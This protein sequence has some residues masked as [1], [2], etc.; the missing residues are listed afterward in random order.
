MKYASIYRC[1]EQFVFL[2][3]GHGARQCPGRRMAEQEL[4][5]LLRAI[6][7]NF[8]VEY[9]HEDIGL[10]VRLFNC[11]DKPAKFSFIPLQETEQ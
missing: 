3:F 7:T 4:D 8:K 6:F 10:Q 11:A 2:P 5:L 1:K 9:H